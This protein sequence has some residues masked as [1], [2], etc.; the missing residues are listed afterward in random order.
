MKILYLHPHAWT[1]EYPILK[2]LRA[3]GH[4]ICVLEEDKNKK[5]RTYRIANYFDEPSDGIPT[6]WYNPK[7]GW[8]KIIT[9]PVDRFFKHAFN[10]RNLGHRM[11]VIRKAVCYFKPDAIIS[12]EGFAYAIPASFLKRMGLLKVVSMVSYIGGDILDCPEA[13]VGKRRTPLVSWLIRQPI[14]SSEI[15]RA[16]SPMVKQELLSFN[17]DANKI[18]ICPS[19]LAIDVET[20]KNIFFSKKNIRSAIRHR[21][22]IPED[23][24]LIVTLSSN[25]K[26][27][28]LHILAEAWPLV[29]QKIPDCRWLLCGPATPWIEQ[30]ALPVLYSHPIENTV[31]RTGRLSGIEVLQS[32]IAAD[33]NVNP[34]LCES[35]NMVVV[36][37][38]AVGVPT[39][40]SDGA[41]IASW[42]E[43]FEAGKV[44]PAGNV[45]ALADAI[46]DFFQ[47]PQTGI[48][49]GKHCAALS[50]NFIMDRIAENL[51]ALLDRHCRNNS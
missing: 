20:L 21:Y 18:H 38:A 10:G 1:G 5:S 43:E 8:E 35:L 2:K 9:W 50:E 36:E 48:T 45:A 51:V 22:K 32:L 17:A 16:V 31:I 13:A 49:W 3:M 25:E 37:A 46:I 26:G 39:I 29:L 4:D 42:V 27:K 47:N 44:V 30:T 24:P 6:F 15:L 7:K 23:F 41:G 28:G 33:V 11:W 14:Q 19:H 40:T 34:S 12:S